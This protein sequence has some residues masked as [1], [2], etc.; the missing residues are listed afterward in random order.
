MTDYN[1]AE[2]LYLQFMRFRREFMDEAISRA[3]YTT[4]SRFGEVFRPVVLLQ[5]E[6]LPSFNEKVEKWTSMAEELSHYPE[7]HIP[8]QLFNPPPKVINGATRVRVYELPAVTVRNWPVEKV[9]DAMRAKIRR[10]QAKPECQDLC[11]RLQQEIEILQ[12]YPAEARIFLRREGFKDTIANV[13]YDGSTEPDLERVS[14]HGLFIVNSPN[15]RLSTKPTRERDSTSP[16]DLIEGM[17]TAMWADTKLYLVEEVEKV[18]QRLADYREKNKRQM[19][20]ATERKSRQKRMLKD[21]VAGTAASKR[22]SD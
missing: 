16:Y 14:S 7:L 13:V 1:R 11:A 15:L 21:A 22:G 4:Q 8:P 6:E 3:E 12:A 2:D 5:P 17:E 19:R 18:R 9:I 10:S 20:T